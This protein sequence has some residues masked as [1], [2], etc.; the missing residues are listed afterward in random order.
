M[1]RII[2]YIIFQIDNIV[3]V[4]F[5]FLST[6]MQFNSLLI[7]ENGLFEMIRRIK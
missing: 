4:L 2:V 1:I 7:M 5:I 6:C 3:D